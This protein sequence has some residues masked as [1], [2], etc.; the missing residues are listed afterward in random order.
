MTHKTPVITSLEVMQAT[1]R[2]HL[3]GQ[4]HLCNPPVS[5]IIALII[6]ANPDLSPLAIKEVLKQTAERRGE[7]SAP[8]IDP[9]WNRDFGYG[10]VDARAAVELAIHL[11]NT[12]QSASLNPSIQHHLLDT[13]KSGNIFTINGHVVTNWC[14]RSCRIQG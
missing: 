2:T 9:Y 3:E 14:C 1:I 6:E 11:G 5:G 8:D 12:N 10:M 4:V 13:S 7:P